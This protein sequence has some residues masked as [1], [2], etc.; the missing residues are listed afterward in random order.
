MQQSLIVTDLVFG[1]VKGPE[2]VEVSD[3]VTL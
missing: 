3:E 2:D 1:L